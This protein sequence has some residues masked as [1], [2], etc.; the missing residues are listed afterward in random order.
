MPYLQI[1]VSVVEGLAARLAAVAGITEDQAIGGLVRLWHLAWTR[2]VDRL[3]QVAVAA[4]FPGADWGRLVAGLVEFEFLTQVDRAW[5][6]RGA[7]RRLG[8]L[9]AR[10]KAIAKTNER[11]WGTRSNTDQS[12][13]SALTNSVTPLISETSVLHPAP[14]TQIPSTQ[15][16]ALAEKTGDARVIDRAEAAGLKLTATPPGRPP[17]KPKQTALEIVDPTWQPLVA[18]LTAS[19]TRIKGSAPGW[20]GLDFKRLKELRGRGSD[21]EIVT[22]WERGLVGTYKREVNSVSELWKSEKWNALATADARGVEPVSAEW[23]DG[24]NFQEALKGELQKRG[25]R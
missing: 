7:D 6:V 18:R 4:C 15:L 24:Q 1:E 13:I 21:D 8:L 12:P 19:F 10:Q 17:R 25:V 5:V 23:N 11:R 3:S 9:S 22:R 16:S 20:E 2:K 14:S